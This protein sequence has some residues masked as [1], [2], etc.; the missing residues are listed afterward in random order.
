MKVAGKH[1]HTHT[2]THSGQ[3]D[4]SNGD[5]YQAHTHKHNCNYMTV[6][7]NFEVP[8]RGT[9]CASMGVCA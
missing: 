2:Y 9:Y 1:S 8:G 3:H 6:K 4:N 5:E 7:L